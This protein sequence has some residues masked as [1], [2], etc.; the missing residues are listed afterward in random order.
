VGSITATYGATQTRQGK[1]VR[2][3]G[4]LAADLRPYHILLKQHGLAILHEGIEKTGS[5]GGSGGARAS[6]RVTRKS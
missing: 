4:N 2:V 3:L 6:A 5:V 1:F